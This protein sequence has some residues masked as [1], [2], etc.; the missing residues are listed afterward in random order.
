VTDLN[1]R[2]AELVSEYYSV[3]SGK[4]SIPFRYDGKDYSLNDLSDSSLCKMLGE[5]ALKEITL[6]CR[7]AINAAAGEIFLE[8]VQLRTELAALYGYDSY[9]AYADEQKYFRDYG[10]AELKQF[11]DSVK[12][13]A[14]RYQPISDTSEFLPY[15]GESIDDTAWLASRLVKKLP[16]AERDSFQTLMNDGL[17]ISG[18]GEGYA[19]G[20]FSDALPSVDSAI[21]YM[22][23]CG[24][25]D[26]TT[27]MHELGHFTDYIVNGY[28]LMDR[29]IIDVSEIHS[30][31][32]EALLLDCFDVVFTKDQA[33]RLKAYELS[34]LLSCVVFGCI[35]DEWQRMV[36]ADP[37]MTL[38]EVNAAYRQVCLSYGR[39]ESDQMGYEW[40]NVHHNYDYPLYYISYS[41]SAVVSMQIYHLSRTDRQAAL[42]AWS[43]FLD[44][45]SVTPYLEA[46]SG[47]GLL[48]FT[49]GDDI[50]ALF[51]SCADTVDALTAKYQ[52]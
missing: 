20:G 41:T 52:K 28:D 44:C 22:R 18:S 26:I 5:D 13:V 50:A 1:R 25:D 31:G 9:A 29:Q 27:L 21:I 43:Y 49:A 19:S 38:D 16:A 15:S 30:T 6:G 48:S 39:Q 7:K 3:I 42:D 14:Y 8:L 10:E 34:E 46:V 35:F 11:Y 37:D 4:D 47:S 32:T 2:I 17:L 24:S 12:S 36:Y 45:G 23:Y 33:E 51:I 40:V